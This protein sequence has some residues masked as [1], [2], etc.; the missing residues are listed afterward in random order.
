MNAGLRTHLHELILVVAWHTGLHGGTAFGAVVT[1]AAGIVCRA[2]RILAFWA[3]VSPG[4]WPRGVHQAILSTVVTWWADNGSA[5]VYTLYGNTQLAPNSRRLSQVLKGQNSM[6]QCLLKSLIK[7]FDI[8]C[9]S[10][11]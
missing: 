2:G 5:R 11:F 6:Q 3:V 10:T 8:C 4:A 7:S 1:R 9:F